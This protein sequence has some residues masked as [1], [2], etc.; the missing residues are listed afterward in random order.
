MS[1][2]YI[3]EANEL[4]VQSAEM[5]SCVPRSVDTYQRW[6]AIEP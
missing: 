3:L 4:G 5:T 6:A 2:I 1:P